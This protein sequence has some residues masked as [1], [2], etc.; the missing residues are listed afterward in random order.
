MQYISLI[1]TGSIFL[2]LKYVIAVRTHVYLVFHIIACFHV[3]VNPLFAYIIILAAGGFI[4]FC[5]K[6]QISILLNP[7]FNKYSNNC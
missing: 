6:I 3:C 4:L 7:D 1:R 2:P 5:I